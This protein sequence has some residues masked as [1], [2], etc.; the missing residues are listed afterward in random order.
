MAARGMR[1]KHPGPSVG[2][3]SRPLIIH[4]D[5]LGI[6]DSVNL[7]IAEAH[8]CGV[9]T[10]ASI[11][12][13]GAA[14]DGAVEICRALPSLDIGVHLTLIEER[15]L[16]PATTVPT[17]IDARNRFPASAFVFAYRYFRGQVDLGE[18][19]RELDAQI[20]RV[21]DAG[22]A[23]SHLDSHQHIHMLPGVFDITVRLA[24]EYAIP[25]LRIPQERLSLTLVGRA[26]SLSRVAQQRAL[27]GFCALASGRIGDL[28]R[29]DHFAGFLFGGAMNRGNL[30]TVLHSLPPTGCAEIMCH[31]SAHSLDAEYAHWGYDGAAEL[32]ALV[33]PDL[34]SLLE[35]LGFARSTY[36]ALGQHG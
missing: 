20:R 30:R 33:D 5:D 29:T 23:V 2:R 12:A 36:A 15:P 4:G 17:L 21:F 9:L 7:G 32:E 26:P 18:I 22:L 10:S 16:L 28:Q 6:S 25:A 3:A 34:P 13:V 8:R 1:P 31:P 11:M 19:H 35:Q 24:R 27:S 14:F